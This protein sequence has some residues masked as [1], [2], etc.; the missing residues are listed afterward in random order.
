ME[1]YYASRCP[2]Q[3]MHSESFT[4]TKRNGSVKLRREEHGMASEEP[5][6]VP[7]LLF[8]TAK[9]YP[10]VMAMRVR[11]GGEWVS[12]TYDQFL[13]E[14]QLIARALINIGLHRHHSA[15]ILGNSSPEWVI[16]NLA[17]IF[18]GYYYDHEKLLY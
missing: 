8:D 14:T 1:N 13:H 9:A 16:S 11:R 5:L 10:E 6:S 12:W 4:S 3:I 18:A 7:S 15:I 17:A 2:L